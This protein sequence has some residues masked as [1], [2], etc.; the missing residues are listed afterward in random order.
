VLLDEVDRDLRA[1]WT[2]WDAGGEPARK[3]EQKKMV[4]LLDRRRYLSNLVRDIKE[5]LGV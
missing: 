4:A 5:V 2:A 3:A 1:S